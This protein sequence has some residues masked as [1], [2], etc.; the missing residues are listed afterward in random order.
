MDR[1]AESEGNE[2]CSNWCSRLGTG[3]FGLVI[4][5]Q[6]TGAE[7]GVIPGILVLGGLSNQRSFPSVSN[8]VKALCFRM[9]TDLSAIMA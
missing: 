3:M 2:S 4:H 6:R 5:S 9:R 7:I 1:R 8:T